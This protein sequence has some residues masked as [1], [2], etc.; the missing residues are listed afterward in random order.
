MMNIILIRLGE[1]LLVYIVFLGVICCMALWGPHLSRA[2]QYSHM[3]AV[4]CSMVCVCV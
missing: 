2:G 4:L 1:V 3:L